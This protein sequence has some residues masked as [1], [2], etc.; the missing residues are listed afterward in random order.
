[1]IARMH[2]SESGWAMVTAVALMAIMLTLGL[3][4]FAAVD[5]GTSQ[6]RKQREME[7]SLNLA[8]GALY[9]QALA[10]ARAWPAGM[11]P[12]FVDR[13]LNTTPATQSNCPN[14]AT[15]SAADAGTATATAA[16]RSVDFLKQG[17]WGTKVRDDYGALECTPASCA[18]DP[19]VADGI[20]TGTKGQC[21]VPPAP[22]A[23]DFDGD[24]QMW[25]QAKTVV[26]GQVRN[27]VAL[28]KLELLAEEVPRAAVSAGA[29]I[30]NNQNNTDRPTIQGNDG[31]VYVACETN[32]AN[33]ATYPNNSKTGNADV[34][35]VPQEDKT[36]V[37]SPLMNA[38]Q[39][40]R[41]KER[42]KIDNKYFAGCPANNADLSGAVVWVE[43]C[44]TPGGWSASNSL[45]SGDCGTYFPDPLLAT[46]ADIC[47]N[48]IQRPGLLIWHC[49]SATFGGSNM[50]VGLIYMVNNSDAST[51]SPYSETCAGMG[52]PG[53]IGNKTCTGNN[54]SPN[55]V[56]RLA[57]NFHLWGAVTIDGPGCLR[58]GSSGMQI[59][60]DRNVFN[61]IRSY[62]T[63]GLVQNTWRE[64]PGNA[65]F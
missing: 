49:G 53:T 51:T 47:I 9:A 26:R 42:A 41:M 54:N 37:G 27:V 7:S 61:A 32:A 22:C 48:T 5:N 2:S 57:G 38:E 10:L 13:C 28:L 18:Y 12:S 23:R 65:A 39:L 55:D 58:A 45:A 62:G 59:Y 14:P 56:L 63:A 19:A 31:G 8:E 21:N 17:T 20:L 24:R 64:L 1:M 35:P 46:S 25:V 34:Q 3:A 40:A 60:Y 36:H 50:Y 15:L 16:F 29:L 6:S 52:L 11:Q 43:G 33:C 30:V 4:T 44:N